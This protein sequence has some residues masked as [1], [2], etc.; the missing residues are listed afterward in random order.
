MSYC[1]RED[2]EALWSAQAV[3]ASVDDDGDT[4]LSAT[5]EG[6]IARAIEMAANEMNQYL[7]IRYAP[8]DLA[9]NEWC[10]DVNAALAVWLLATRD[11]SAAPQSIAERR[12]LCLDALQDIAEGR[13]RVPGAVDSLESIPTATNFTTD[14]TAPHAKV[15][16]VTET[17]TGALPAGGRKSFPA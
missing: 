12:S 17:T 4:L 11:G 7:A 5:E 1:I 6:Y 13:W 10:R 15:R 16:R 2:L 3:L 8:A 14:L 9:G